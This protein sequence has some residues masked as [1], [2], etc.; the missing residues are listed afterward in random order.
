MSFLIYPF[1]WKNN[2]FF[3]LD[4]R[5]LPFEK[6]YIKCDTYKDV[7]KCIKNMSVRG[8]PAIGV[9]SGYGMYLAVKNYKGKN[10]KDYITK[11]A[12]EFISCRP[13]AYNISYVVNRIKNFSLEIS[14]NKVDYKVIE[15]VFKEVEEIRKENKKML[16]KVVEN[17]LKLLKKNSCVLTHC[18]TGVLACGD[19]GSALGV[20]IEGY[21]N[22]KVS[23]VFVDE[24]RPYLQGARLTMLELIS[25]GIP[26]CMI[27]DN[28]AGYVIKEKK[29]DCII[30]GADRIAKNGDTANKIG[31]Y[32]LAILAKYH[33]IPFYVVAPSSSIDKNISTGKEIK[34]EQR[35][36]DEVKYINGKPIT[37]ETANVLHPAFDVTP[38]ELITA[39]VTEEGIFRYPYNFR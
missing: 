4:Q 1:I 11:V 8:A 37:L 30:V 21:K 19:V 31:T 24:T 28:M 39:I 34:I 18:N 14:K 13:T 7:I 2:S 9:V 12:N 33:K 27:T 5:K 20:I 35:G 15:L 16:Q 3:I 6:E 38:A 32:T 29:V 10:F 17:G 26:C 36:E 22:K 25:A 23:F